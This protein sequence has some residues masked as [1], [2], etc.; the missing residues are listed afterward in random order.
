MSSKLNVHI[1][2]CA[3]LLGR[4]HLV[5]AYEVHAEWLISF[6]DKRVRGK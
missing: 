3:T 5:N 1:W 6:V 4:R 2:M